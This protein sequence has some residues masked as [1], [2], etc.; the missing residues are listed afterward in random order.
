MIEHDESDS[1]IKDLIPKTKDNT[2][3]FGFEVANKNDNNSHLAFN[4][5]DFGNDDDGIGDC[6]ESGGG[7]RC[8]ADR[9]LLDS[10]KVRWLVNSL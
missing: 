4:F 2:F 5:N 3:E 6:S 7:A 10:P 8:G 1:P 9:G